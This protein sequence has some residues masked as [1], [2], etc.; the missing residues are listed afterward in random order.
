VAIPSSGNVREL[1]ALT[2][3]F[4]SWYVQHP[5]IADVGAVLENLKNFFRYYPEFDENRAITALDPYEVAE[6]IASLVINAVYEGF[7]AAYSLMQFLHFLHDSGRWSGS[8]ESYRAVNGILTDII[9]LDT[10]A[11]LRA[12]RM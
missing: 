4:I 8:S 2:P 10:S 1:E 5:F 6:K 11:R 12:P 9:W 7:A 3:A